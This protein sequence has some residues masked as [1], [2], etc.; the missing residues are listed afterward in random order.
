[1]EDLL[2]LFL[3]L[4][5]FIFIILAPVKL[6]NYLLKVR[7]IKINRWILAMSAFIILILIK[8][9][10]TNIPSIIDKLFMFLFIVS[11]VMFFEISRITF[12]ETKHKGVIDYSKYLKR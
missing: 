4:I 3:N 1:M 11:I 8:L 2:R 12:E 9:F 7:K 5:I 6:T 10:W